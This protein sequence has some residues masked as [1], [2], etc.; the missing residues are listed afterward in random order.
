MK[1]LGKIGKT[2]GLS[3]LF[4]HHKIA[5]SLT[6]TTCLCKKTIVPPCH[7][8]YDDFQFNNH[9]SPDLEAIHFLH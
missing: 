2:R 6:P 5:L 8:K 1:A 9:S 3:P 4:I 7:L